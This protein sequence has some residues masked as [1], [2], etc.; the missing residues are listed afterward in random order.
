[1]VGHT[2]LPTSASAS[3]ALPETVY[4]PGSALLDPAGLLREMAAEIRDGRELAVRLFQRDLKAQ[5]RQS[6]LGYAWLFFPPVATTLVWFFLN[7]SGVVQVAKTDIPYPIFV[8]IGTLL[9]TAFL[10]SLVKPIQALESARSMMIK[11][12]FPRIAPIIAGMGEIT[13]TAAIRLVLLIPVF[14]YLSALPAWTIVFFPLAYLALVLCGTAIGVLLTPI[15]LLYT[16]IARAI[17]LLGQFAMYAT[18]VVYPVAT[19]GLLKEVNFLNPVTYLIETGRDTLMG[20]TFDYLPGALVVTA[21]GVILLA[22]GWTIFH[23]TVPRIIERM[24][25]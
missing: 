19:E 4:A 9:W 10:D 16:D 1:M 7:S 23:I 21:L 6:V 8:M 20:G 15:G 25:M 5:F 18:P 24:G 2:E 14:L 11:L 22:I 13:I 12:N 17:R 3:D